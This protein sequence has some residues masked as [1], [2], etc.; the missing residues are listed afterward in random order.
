MATS[1]NV[2]SI[3][4]ALAGKTASVDIP[5]PR[6]NAFAGRDTF[7]NA[8]AKSLP[9]AK[10][11]HTL[12][13]PPNSISPTLPPHGFRGQRAP[14]ASTPTALVNVDSDIDLQD[15]I[16]HAKSQSQPQHGFAT[17]DDR[18]S[19]VGFDAAGAITPGL[20][21][22]HHLPEILLDHGPLAIRHVM[23]HLTTSVP[24]FSSIPPAKA[25][26][27]VV[28]ALEGRGNG[29][30]GGGVNGDVEFEKVGWGRWDAK[31]KGQQSRED[32][33]MQPNGG[34]G[35]TL[36]PPPS[37]PSSYSALSADGVPSDGMQIPKASS[38]YNRP[39]G[40]GTGDSWN[41]D[42]AVFS[43]DEDMN[44]GYHEDITMLEN[45]ADKMSLDGDESCSSS[46]AP[47]EG[48]VM[49]EDVGDITD[50][51]DWARIGAAALRQPSVPTSGGGGFDHLSNDVYS[52]DRGGGPASSALAKSMPLT[53]NFQQVHGSVGFSHLDGFG[54]GSD[55]QEREAIEAL[56]RLSSV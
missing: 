37:A 25:R 54:A 45:E 24:G 15:A 33:G 8:A 30:E 4:M 14:V 34:H 49:D 53:Y 11:P 2:S 52:G 41:G 38:R 9:A 26:R 51:E 3:A 10:Q 44:S 31:I 17:A 42:A 21:A 43:H 19:A 29:G 5:N 36:S 27:L 22:K 6:D 39:W 16:D 55:A 35:N 56:V 7:G 28:G 1:R 50:E 23:G 46:E 48:P 12:P 13:T 47:D 18:G 20:L 40:Y 32:R